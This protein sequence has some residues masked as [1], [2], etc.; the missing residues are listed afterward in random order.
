M[1]FT[2]TPVFCFTQA[3]P[4]IANL[5]MSEI[6][7]SEAFDRKNTPNPPL[8]KPYQGIWDTGASGSV[9]NSHV[10]AELGLKPSGK[11]LATAVGDGGKVNQYITD[12]YTINIVLPNKVGVV[13]VVAA[14]GEIGGADALI[15][16][17]IIGTGDFASTN[18]DGKTKMSF[19]TP[20]AEEIDFV[21]EANEYNRQHKN[22]FQ[23]DEQRRQARNKRK[24]ERRKHR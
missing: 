19:G 4:G 8:G 9:I 22:S 5:L 10:S 7:I 16:M 3:F 23:T 6:L 11:I 12:T 21:E 2:K 20:S 15:G 14:K 1:K 24:A 18:K 13:G 17:D